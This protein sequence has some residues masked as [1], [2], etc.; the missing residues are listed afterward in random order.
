MW[1]LNVELSKGAA[2]SEPAEERASKIAGA[3][4]VLR[5]AK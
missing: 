4:R 2:F 3:F 1:R 5:M